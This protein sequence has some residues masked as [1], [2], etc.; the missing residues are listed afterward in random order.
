MSTA[1]KVV[2]VSGELLWE[3]ASVERLVIGG[4]IAPVQL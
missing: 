1:L 3:K 4:V 2:E